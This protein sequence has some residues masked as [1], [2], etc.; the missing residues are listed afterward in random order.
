MSEILKH[1][2]QLAVGG[3]VFGNAGITSKHLELGYVCHLCTMDKDGRFVDIAL[4]EK[5]LLDLKASL[6]AGIEH[7]KAKEPPQYT[8]TF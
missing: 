8:T 2:E 6:D 7:I 3:V 1:I 5:H 4:T